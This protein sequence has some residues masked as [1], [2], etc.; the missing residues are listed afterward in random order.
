MDV[1]KGRSNRWK[2]RRFLHNP[3]SDS[4]GSGAFL[5]VFCYGQILGVL[6]VS[7]CV[8]CAG[9]RGGDYRPS[10]RIFRRD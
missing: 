3:A 10:I 8:M 4:L 7:A 5:L 9:E 6:V 1:G 2:R